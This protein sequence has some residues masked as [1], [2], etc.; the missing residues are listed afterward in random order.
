LI[1]TVER[2]WAKAPGWFDG[3]TIDQ[4]RSALGLHLAEIGEHNDRMEAE[5]RER[6][7]RERERKKRRGR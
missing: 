7:E 1:L 2:S 3:L 4:Q 5:K 6:E